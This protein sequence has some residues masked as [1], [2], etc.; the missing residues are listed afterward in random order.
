MTRH[1]LRRVSR[2]GAKAH[3]RI[4]KK[5]F[6]PS[7]LSLRLCVKLIVAFVVIIAPSSV[8][9]QNGAID[10]PRYQDMAVDLMQQYLRDQYFKSAGQ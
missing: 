8:S 6:A 4:A 3:A 1:L 10:W 9:A 2:K 5:N 7:V